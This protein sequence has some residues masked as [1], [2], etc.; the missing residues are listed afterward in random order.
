MC[1]GSSS[2]NRFLAGDKDAIDE[3]IRDYIDG[4]IFYIYSIIGD[5]DLAEET[6]TDVFIKLYADKPKFK[7]DSAFKTWL[8]KIGRNKAL[9]QL[10]RKKRIS[11]SET[12]L[13]DA[14][15]VSDDENIEQNYIQQ[16]NNT[17]LRHL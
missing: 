12:S 17:L 7:G 15:S 13:D 1:D 16:E 14:Y 4:L 8:Y 3:L 9:N 10:R 5:M 6:A 11:V 2:Y